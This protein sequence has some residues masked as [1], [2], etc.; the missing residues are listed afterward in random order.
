MQ[1]ALKLLNIN[2]SWYIDVTDY[3]MVMK[4]NKP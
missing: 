1:W 3:T 4:K 2:N